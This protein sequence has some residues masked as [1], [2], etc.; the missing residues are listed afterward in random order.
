[1]PSS[2]QVILTRVKNKGRIQR[3]QTAPR[4]LHSLEP[5][6]HHAIDLYR[7][8]PQG[9]MASLHLLPRQIREKPLHTFGQTRRQRHIVGRLDEQDR[10]IDRV[11]LK[12]VNNFQCRRV[13]RSS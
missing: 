4:L 2:H 5:F 10:H 3:S 11:L 7:L 9:P 8:L 12:P 6:P 1:M 13:I